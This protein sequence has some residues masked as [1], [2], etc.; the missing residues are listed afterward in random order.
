MI[1]KISI[2]PAIV[3][4][5]FASFPSPAAHALEIRIDYTYDTGNFFNTQLKRDAIEAVADFYGNMIN[6]TLLRIDPAD[7]SQASWTAT[8][9]HPTTGGTQTISELVVPEGVII[10]YVGAR[11]LGGSTAGS[12]G[13]GGF[14][15]SG[16]TSWFER[17]RG[18]GSAAAAISPA[19]S[20]TDF[21]LWGGSI[22]FDTPRTWNFSQSTNATG[23]EFISIALHEM[24]HVLGL[25]SAD[26]WDNLLNAGT[27]TGSAAALSFGSAPT[28]DNGH[29][30]GSQTSRLF[31]SFSATHGTT[32]PV[33]MLPLSTDTGSNFD[34]ATDLD[35]SALVDIG[36]ELT[37]P[38]EL[39][40]T[41]LSPGA[42]SFNWQSVSFKNYNLQRSTNL[43]TFPGGSGNISGNGTL[44]SWTDPAP[45]SEKAF[46]RLAASDVNPVA[47]VAS[48]PQAMRAADSENT[49]KSISE[50]PRTVENCDLAH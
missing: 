37:P 40:T 19:S 36:W 4:A 39:K 46:Y 31:G 2:V 33:L 20:R 13:P 41:A 32:R 6:D 15:A 30:T 23:T 24:G 14:S 47:S 12:A 17:I 21:A 42:V 9:T 16:F 1:S 25:G 8:I 48:I 38:V 44:K 28:A 45:P 22:S 18:R 50:D 27:F 5:T 7:F 34:V 49:Y 11:E 3:L 26:S 10:V 43:L 35:L 29:F